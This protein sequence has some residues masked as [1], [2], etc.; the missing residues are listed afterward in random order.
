QSTSDS[1]LEKAKSTEATIRASVVTEKNSKASSPTASESSNSSTLSNKVIG[2][3]GSVKSKAANLNLSLGNNSNV[4]N[5]KN[6]QIIKTASTN[7]LNSSA[8]INYKTNK[9]NLISDSAISKSSYSSS[10]TSLIATNTSIRN[11]TPNKSSLFGNNGGVSSD[12]T[13][14]SPPV[15]NKSPTPGIK[16]MPNHGKPNFAPKPPGLQQLAFANGQ[17]PLVS[18]HHSMKS[19]RS[20]PISSAGG[21]VFP[22]QQHFGTLRTPQQLC[23]SQDAINSNIRTAPNPPIGRPTVAPPKPPTV[24]PPPPP[25]PARSISNSNLNSLTHNATNS[26]AAPCSAVNTALV[27]TVTGSS[28]TPTTTQPPSNSSSSSSV[29]TLRE[30]FKNTQSAPTTPPVSAAL[31]NKTTGSPVS[32]TNSTRDKNVKPIILNGGP[33]NAPPLPPHRTCPA[34]PPPQRQSS[35]TGSGAPPVPP[36]RHSSIRANAPIT[37]PTTASAPLFGN[38]IGNNIS[39]A[40]SVS[41]LVVDLEAKFGKRFHNVT[42]FPKPPPFLNVQK[43]YPSRTV[44]ATNAPNENNNIT[45]NN[46]I[47]PVTTNPITAPKPLQPAY[48]PF[49]K[50]RAPAPPPQAGV[51]A[52]TVSV[53]RQSSFLY[54]GNNSIGQAQSQTP[55]ATEAPRN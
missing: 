10:T 47:N 43:I 6:S 1:V 46:N 50:H 28:S 33:I 19:P 44:K 23:Q 20:P 21:P 52:A 37:P 12:S 55:N 41:R 11:L 5:N 2:N 30:Q 15:M 7:S 38:N 35:N 29:S 16:P 34:P 14:P 42:E 4:V 54:G 17:R 8:S 51:A 27:N 3:S 36:Q 13:T 32:K 22:T 39:N 53:I 9:N 26:S 45:N 18:R 24:K 31:T 48:Q 25:T 40:N 49:K